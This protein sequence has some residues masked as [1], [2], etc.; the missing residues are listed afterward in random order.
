MPMW[1]IGTEDGHRGP[2]GDP[3]KAHPI[4][5]PRCVKRGKSLV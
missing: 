4:E 5:V 1:P 2:N 3:Q